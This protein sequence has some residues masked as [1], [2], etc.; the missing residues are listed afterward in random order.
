MLNA[1]PLRS[2]T[3]GKGCTVLQGGSCGDEEVGQDE[4]LAAGRTCS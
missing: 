2:E 4:G 3:E 1:L